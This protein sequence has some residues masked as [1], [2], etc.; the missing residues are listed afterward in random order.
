MLKAVGMF[1][2]MDRLVASIIKFEEMDGE[3][4]P[5]FG[6]PF[7][8]K[9]DGSVEAVELTDVNDP[10]LVGTL[11]VLGQMITVTVD[12]KI[13]K[14]VMEPMP[15]PVDAGTGVATT[16]AT[17]PPEMILTL[18]DIMDGD[19]VMVMPYYDDTG[20][21]LIARVIEVKPAPEM[22]MSKVFGPITAVAEAGTDTMMATIVVAG[23]T[24]VI[25]DM[26]TEITPMDKYDI[27]KI[28]AAIE[29]G[30]ELKAMVKG[31]YD[32]K[33]DKLTA[34]HIAVHELNIM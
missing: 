15:M 17:M 20:T 14:E 28:A 16:M 25:D 6:V 30:A 4:P 18:A 1:D 11:K 31:T 3:K 13:Y 2:D 22:P 32:M 29:K 24:V 23:V 5:M 26:V 19:Y 10:K 33:T 7:M 9:Y 8:I 34:K 12:T 21:T 27:A